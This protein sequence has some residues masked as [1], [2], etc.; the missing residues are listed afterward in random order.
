[1]KR[2]TDNV[3]GRWLNSR[4]PAQRTPDEVLNFFDE[5][6]AEGL[7]LAKT[8]LVHDQLVMDTVRWTLIS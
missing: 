3:L 5:C 1:M 4:P 2:L 7:R 6:W 8:S